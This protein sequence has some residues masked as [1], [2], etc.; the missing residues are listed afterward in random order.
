M[1]IF[2]IWSWTGWETITPSAGKLTYKFVQFQNSRRDHVGIKWW[3]YDAIFG[4]T[5]K[6]PIPNEILQDLQ[7]YL[8]DKLSDNAPDNTNSNVN[9]NVQDQTKFRENVSQVATIYQNGQ[10]GWYPE[11]IKFYDQLISGIMSP[12]Q[13][14]A[15]TKE[16]AIEGI[17][18]T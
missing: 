18:Y 14:P 15:S 6:V 10:K 17:F 13:Y 12:Y 9:S 16:V 2:T 7:A 11:V 1:V 4:C 8:K 5:P 3:P